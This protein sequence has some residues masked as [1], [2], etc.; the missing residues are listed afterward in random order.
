[1]AKYRIRPY[2]DMRTWDTAEN[3]IEARQKRCDLQHRFIS[4][5]IIVVD[6]NEQEV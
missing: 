4:R 5:R 3:L 2:D 1:M 6:E